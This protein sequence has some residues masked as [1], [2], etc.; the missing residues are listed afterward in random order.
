MRAVIYARYSSD[1]QREASIEDQLSL[2]AER[3][4]REGWTVVGNYSDRAASGPIC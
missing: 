3:A 1:L 2:C 4:K